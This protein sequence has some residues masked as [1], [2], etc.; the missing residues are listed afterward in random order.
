[1]GSWF[2]LAIGYKKGPTGYFLLGFM[3]FD[4]VEIIGRD[5]QA[6][7]VCFAVSV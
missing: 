6:A 2:E 1:V 3:F 7:L 4:I 5:A